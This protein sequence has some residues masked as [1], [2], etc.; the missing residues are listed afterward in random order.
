MVTVVCWMCVEKGYLWFWI[1]SE[2]G[3]VVIFFCLGREKKS[4]RVGTRY[5]QFWRVEKIK[6]E[7]ARVGNEHG[8]EKIIKTGG[9]RW[10]GEYS[11]CLPCCSC[12]SL[13][14]QQILAGDRAVGGQGGSCVEGKRERATDMH[15]E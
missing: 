12:P 7:G 8:P 5:W 4:N 13:L 11:G 15:R 14:A 10:E 2:E 6:R 9:E 1:G 3:R